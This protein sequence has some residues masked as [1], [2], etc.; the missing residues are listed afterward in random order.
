[1]PTQDD[2]PLGDEVEGDDVLG[3]VHRVMERQ[4]DHRGADA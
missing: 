4:Q 1:M 2:A 3:H